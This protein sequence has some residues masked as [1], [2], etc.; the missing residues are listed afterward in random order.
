MSTNQIQMVVTYHS[1]MTAIGYEWGSKNH[2]GNRDKSPDDHANRDI[3]LL[4]SRYG[5]EFRDSKPYPG[6]LIK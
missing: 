4:M 6:I 2:M 1:G 5:G 3:A